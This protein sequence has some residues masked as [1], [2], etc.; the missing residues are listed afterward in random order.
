M[1]DKTDFLRP[2][3][4]Y[5]CSHNSAV[6]ISMKESFLFIE[7]TMHSIEIFISRYSFCHDIIITRWCIT[8]ITIYDILYHHYIFEGDFYILCQ[9]IL[10]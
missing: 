1:G 6:K 9:N 2:G 7:F 10:T 8:I 5:E 3:H 4:I